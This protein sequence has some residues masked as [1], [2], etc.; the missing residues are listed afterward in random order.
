MDSQ[1]PESA[2]GGG[3]VPAWM[4]WNWRLR[5]CLVLTLPAAGGRMEF[6]WP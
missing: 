5:R 3:P 2:L 4:A 6:V 1:K